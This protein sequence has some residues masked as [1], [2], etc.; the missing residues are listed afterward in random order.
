MYTEAS[1]GPNVAPGSK[2]RLVM[3]ARMHTSTGNC[4]RF[5]YHMYGAKMGKGLIT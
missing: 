4:V 2:A 5:W 3:T 1:S